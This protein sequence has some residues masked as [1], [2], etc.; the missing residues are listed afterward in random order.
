MLMLLKGPKGAV[1]FVLYTM[2]MPIPEKS[3]FS[4]DN[5]FGPLPADL[6]YHSP[7]PMYEG[8][9]S[10]KDCP[11][12]DAGQLCYY[13]GSGC[14]AKDA[15]NILVVKG[16]EALWEFM[17]EYYKERFGETCQG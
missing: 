2:W 13:D 11:W 16:E 17:E 15:Y 8:Q 10:H 3:L 5:N 4:K 14:N 6:G 9:S 7:K 1:Q 12:L